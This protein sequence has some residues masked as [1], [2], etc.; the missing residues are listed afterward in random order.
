MGISGHR[1]PSGGAVR[2]GLPPSGDRWR[3]ATRRIVAIGCQA[4]GR[5]E[6]GFHRLATGGYGRLMVRAM[7]PSTP[8][9]IRTC[10]LS[11]RKAALYPTELLGHQDRRWAISVDFTSCPRFVH[12]GKSNTFPGKQAFYRASDRTRDCPD[13]SN[14]HG[15]RNARCKDRFGWG[16]SRSRRSHLE[17]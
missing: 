5:C 2:G 8:G 15:R 3:R 1:L 9:R 7:L 17:L 16:A 10:D 4:V 11:F 6:E 14:G 12:L 13:V